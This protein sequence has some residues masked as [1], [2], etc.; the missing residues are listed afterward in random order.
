VNLI[1]FGPPGA[2][3]GTQADNLV[4][5]FKHFKVST[6]DLLREEIKKKSL[7]GNEIKSIIDK[8]LMVS[9]DAINGL[10]ESIL[11]DNSYFNRL[12]F[13]GYPRNLNQV[14]ILD[15]LIKKYNQKI[16]CVLSLKVNQNVIIKRII[17]RQVCSKCGLVFNEFF[18]PST[19]ENHHCDIKF[20]QKRSDDNEKTVRNR[21]E[22]Y[23][24]ETL[25]VLNYYK[26][27]NLLYEIDGTND[28]NEIY[29]EIRRIIHSLET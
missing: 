14:K 2:G 17:G 24:K 19:K 8:G 9:D 11:S 4:R 1:L 20:L 22:T 15:E 12:I 7:L 29:K 25:P 3:K 21:F 26:N 10:V 18:N 23:T 27:Q 6:G 28:I 5:E 13:D 16:S